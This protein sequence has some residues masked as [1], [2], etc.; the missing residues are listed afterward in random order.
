MAAECNAT[1]IALS[2]C[3]LLSRWRNNSEKDINYLFELAR[4][5]QP[6]IVLL[7]DI[8]VLYTEYNEDATKVPHE[9]S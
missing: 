4:S 6:S 7:D 1:F 9:F 8:D 2:S 3:E 5:R